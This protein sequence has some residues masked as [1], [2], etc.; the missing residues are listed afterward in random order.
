MKTFYFLFVMILLSLGIIIL[1]IERVID[2]DWNF[3]VIP[4]IILFLY[5]LV[6]HIRDSFK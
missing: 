1:K 5:S 4:T 3:V 2:W 6:I